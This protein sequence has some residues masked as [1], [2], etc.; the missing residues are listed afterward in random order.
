MGEK[1]EFMSYAELEDLKRRINELELKAETLER[2]RGL[3]DKETENAQFWHDKAMLYRNKLLKVQG[4]LKQFIEL[5]S[6]QTLAKVATVQVHA[7][8][9]LDAATYINNGCK[10]RC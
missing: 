7:N 4:D 10:P 8:H 9:T 2:I 1:G 3:L 6:A 5:D